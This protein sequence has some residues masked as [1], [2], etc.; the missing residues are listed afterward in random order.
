MR[1]ATLSNESVVRE[2]A[3]ALSLNPPPSHTP[4]TA[5]ERHMCCSGPQFGGASG[6]FSHRAFPNRR[7]QE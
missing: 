2:L 5:G 7:R 1:F 4:D 3:G 6:D